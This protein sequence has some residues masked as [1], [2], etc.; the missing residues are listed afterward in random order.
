MRR[1]APSALGDAAENATK[2]CG[3]LSKL[4][5][6]TLT[7]ASSQAMRVCRA[8]IQQHVEACCV[9]QRRRQAAEILRAPRRNARIGRIGGLREILLH[10]VIDCVVGQ[11]KR[12]GEIVHRGRVADEVEPRINQELQNR[13][14]RRCGIPAR[15]SP[16]NC[17]PWNRRRRRPSSPAHHSARRCR[18]PTCRRPS[19][20]RGRQEIC[21]LA[22]SDIRRDRTGAPASFAIMLQRRWQSS[23]VPITPPPKW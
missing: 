12:V 9:D 14:L 10:E 22:P 6:A 7:P 5:Y 11:W 8:L 1:M 13:R 17:R 23:S 3:R 4:A 18:R 21:T 2:P 20:L 15:R 16:R 19:H